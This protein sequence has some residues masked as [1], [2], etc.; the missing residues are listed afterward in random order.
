MLL[1]SLPAHRHHIC[2]NYYASQLAMIPIILAVVILSVV[3]LVFMIFSPVL[4]GSQ[5]ELR[6]AIPTWLSVRI[7]IMVFGECRKLPLDFPDAI[8]TCNTAAG[9]ITHRVPFRR[10]RS[11]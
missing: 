6:G 11:L 4:Y 9:S 7:T 8:L 2:Q 1:A 10:R 5:D 3:I